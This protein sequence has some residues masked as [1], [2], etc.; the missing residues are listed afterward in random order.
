LT[1][2]ASLATWATPAERDYRTANLKNFA[3]RGGGRKGEQLQNQVKHLAGWPTP[4]VVDDNNS[5]RGPESVQKQIDRENP[6]NSLA[7][8]AT[9][10]GPVRLTAGGEM[11]TGSDAGMESS[12]Q[13]NPEHSLW[14]QGIPAVWVSFALRAM[15][16]VSRRRK[17]SSKRT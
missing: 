13:L 5:R 9:L 4:S 14:L 12:G 1:D 7:I 15:Q 16:S 3:E 17:R 2:A 11:L 8:K 10:S 6:M